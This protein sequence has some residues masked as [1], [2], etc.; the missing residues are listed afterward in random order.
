MR[1][2]VVRHEIKFQKSV[3]LILALLAV[4]VFA[5]AFTP[6]FSA[7]SALAELSSYDTLRVQ[8]SGSVRCVGCD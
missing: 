1:E 8:L 3:I 2:R 4:S 7:K 5:M 6:L